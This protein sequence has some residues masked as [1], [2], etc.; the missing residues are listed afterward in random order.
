MVNI[1]QNYEKYYKNENFLYLELIKIKIQ[2]AL[3]EHLN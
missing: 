1:V 2:T 3:R